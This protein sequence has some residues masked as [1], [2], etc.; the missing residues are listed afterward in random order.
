M[1]D[2]ESR[3]AEPAGEELDEYRYKREELNSGTEQGESLRGMAGTIDLEA[4]A[5]DDT[6]AVAGEY[7]VEEVSES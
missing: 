2:R 3:Q 1:S 4:G 6:S 5:A 7:P